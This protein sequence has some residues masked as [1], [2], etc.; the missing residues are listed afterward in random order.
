MFVLEGG[1]ACYN[2]D[3]LSE[4]QGLVSHGL[5]SYLALINIDLKLDRRISTPQSLDSYCPNV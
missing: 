5:L 3:I 1:L 4:D 2:P